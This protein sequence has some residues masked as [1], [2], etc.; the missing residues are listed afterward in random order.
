MK[1]MRARGDLAAAREYF[2]RAL[3]LFEAR[4]ARRGAEK[5]R[6]SIIKLETRR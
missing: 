2:T 3:A 5:A 1:T 6:E 4:E